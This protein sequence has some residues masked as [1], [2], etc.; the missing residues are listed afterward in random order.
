M[1]L[2]QR[3]E[4][5]TLRGSRAYRGTYLIRGRCGR[6][7]TPKFTRGRHLPPP[8]GINEPG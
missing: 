5:K 4:N 1:A 8:Y 7:V 6:G 2:T 3:R